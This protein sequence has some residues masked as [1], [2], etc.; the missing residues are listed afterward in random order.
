MIKNILWDFDGVLIDSNHIRENGFIHV[1][2]DFPQD[3]IDKLIIFHKLNGG[4]SRYVKFRYF[5]ET[6]RNEV[7]EDE[8]IDKYCSLFSDIMKKNLLNPNLLINETIN[9]VKN[10]YLNYNM[11]IVSGSDQT[12]LRYLVGEFDLTKYFKGIYGSPKNKID[13]VREILDLNNFR[14]EQ[15]VLIGDSINDF[16]A[17]SNNNISFV[18]Y[19]NIEIERLSNFKIKFV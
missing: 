13:L 5:F 8:I 3:Q 1:L 6:I 18:G 12:E 16:D 9:F 17:A 15:S 14:P 2:K 7:C 4:L 10:N 11:F 19:N